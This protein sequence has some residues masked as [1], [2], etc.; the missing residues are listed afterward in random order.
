MIAQDLLELTRLYSDAPADVA[1]QEFLLGFV[2]VDDRYLES[3]PDAQWFHTLR[4]HDWTQ[5]KGIENGYYNALRDFNL[6]RKLIL[7]RG[8][9]AG[10]CHR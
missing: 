6:R 1:Q 7:R 8:R 4:Q 3:S 10:T 2:H 5:Y 9:R